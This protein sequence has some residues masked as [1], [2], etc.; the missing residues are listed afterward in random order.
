MALTR[1]EIPEILSTGTFDRF[2]GA[3]ET[4]Y[5]DAK[6]EPYQ[7]TDNGKLEIAKDVSALAN[8]AGGYIIIGM[9]TEPSRS[10]VSDEVKE[11]RLVRADLVDPGKYTNVL[12]DWIYPRVTDLSVQFHPS[13]ADVS[14]GVVAIVV[15]LQTEATKP[16]LV[17][18]SGVGAK[19]VEVLFGYVVRKG[20]TNSP[21]KIGDIQ[22]ALRSGLYFEG[23]L[24]GRLDRIEERLQQ[25]H[26][27]DVTR[28]NASSAEQIEQ[29]LESRIRDVVERGD[30]GSGG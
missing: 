30:R 27:R 11:L 20:A 2:V 13:H 22:R 17:V 21:L 9:R 28:V 19:L 5:F 7:D 14:K 3:I 4:A 1:E 15:P 29:R 10:H 26:E 18:R 16:F 24:D 6:R 8:D 23:T 12:N 25:L